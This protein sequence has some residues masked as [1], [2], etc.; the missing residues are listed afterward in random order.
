MLYLVFEVFSVKYFLALIVDNRALLIHYI[1]ILKDVFT[2][3][4]VFAFKV[5]LRIFD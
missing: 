4:E 2:P 5:L 3:V 1:V